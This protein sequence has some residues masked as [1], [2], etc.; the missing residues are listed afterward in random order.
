MRPAD[1]SQL[2]AV[3]YMLLA[4]IRAGGGPCSSEDGA[5]VRLLPTLQ[6][7]V[8]AEA[9]AHTRCCPLPLTLPPPLGCCAGLARGADDPMAP[10]LALSL[11]ATQLRR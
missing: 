5:R 2:T 1:P 10:P 7:A 8:L 3:Q 6:G 4:Q 11:L 9:A